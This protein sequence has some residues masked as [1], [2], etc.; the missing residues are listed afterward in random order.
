[1]AAASPLALRDRGGAKPG[2][3]DPPLGDDE[4]LDAAVAAH[5]VPDRVA[6]ALPLLEQPALGRPVDH[7]QPG[8]LLCQAGELAGGVVHQPV[9]PDHRELGEVVVAADLEV[10]RIVAGRDLER[11]GAELALD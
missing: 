4:W 11:A 9:G 7:P 1:N 6:V 3:R 5:A 2:P 8:L 10:G